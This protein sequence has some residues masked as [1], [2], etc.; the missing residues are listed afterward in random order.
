MVP[1][2]RGSR[3]AAGASFARA[4]R[5]AGVVWLVAAVCAPLLAMPSTSRASITMLRPKPASQ[6]GLPARADVL[7][8]EA[9]PGERNVVS[10][11]FDLDGEEGVWT[12]QDTGA[13]MVAVAPCRKSDVHIVICTAREGRFIESAQLEL[14]DLPDAWRSVTPTSGGSDLRVHG[15]PG[16]DELVGGVYA[17]ALDGGDGN[18]LVVGGGSGDRLDGGPGDDR[19]LGGP[20][21]D[22]LDGGGG[23]DEIMGGG[24]DDQMTDG[25]RDDAVGDAGPGPDLLDGGPDLLDRGG[26]RRLEGC[27]LGDRVSYR[28]RRAPVSVDLGGDA[29][30]GEAGEGDVLRGTESVDGG[31]G[32]DQLL[33]NHD[34][35]ALSGEAG[36]D[37]LVGRGRSDWLEPG[38][39]GGPI[40]CGGGR[41]IVLV[42][43]S[44]DELD[45][46]C[47]F[48]DSE[49]LLLAYTVSAYP[50]D[51]GRGELTARAA[52]PLDEDAIRAIVRCAGDVQLREARGDRRLL[53][54]GAF[55]PARKG[56]RT[57]LLRLT[58]LGARLGT[59]RRGVRATV[60]LEV[61]QRDPPYFER[62]SAAIRWG[63]QLKLDP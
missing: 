33:G 36:R 31:H 39:G 8:Y 10:T 2:R 45:A 59:R 13:Q 52:C 25:D 40:A 7:H 19:L 37:R 60:H 32:D 21:R 29:P 62:T 15:G 4:V 46:E 3:S 24:G 56:R 48:V 61:S 42:R 50:R 6:D 41:D 57:V 47:E 58:E 30:A 38:A 5:L 53:A 49:R 14:G 35:N 1:R 44:E 43:S 9:A 27:C 55:P 28:G 11:R 18:D 23:R 54:R 22:V 20:R 34:Q 26:Q 16:D 63:I 17:A 12:I 51:R